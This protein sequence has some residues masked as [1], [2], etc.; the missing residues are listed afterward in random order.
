MGTWWHISRIRADGAVLAL[1]VTLVGYALFWLI[2]GGR[3][4]AGRWSDL[5]PFAG[6]GV[7]VAALAGI[8]IFDPSIT[9]AQEP[10]QE[11]ADRWMRTTFGG[12]SRYLLAIPAILVTGLVQEPAKVVAALLGLVVA[13][14]GAGSPARR[15]VWFGAVAGAA[16][17]GVEAAVFLSRM[18]AQAPELTLATLGAPVLERFLAVLFHLAT[19]AIVVLR[20]A[21]VGAKG[22]I[23]A[24]VA[25]ALVH[26]VMEYN[27]LLAPFLGTLGLQMIVGLLE[28]LVFGY[29]ALALWGS[30]AARRV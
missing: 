15:A 1:A 14:R 27:F 4:R 7:M 26:A 5:T 9:L 21:Q 30:P 17:G 11:A 18:I 23:G 12:G 19:P 3:R 22:G 10:L 24:L 28:I 16:Y 13:G 6:L 2:V 29:M 25:V 20:W 8:I